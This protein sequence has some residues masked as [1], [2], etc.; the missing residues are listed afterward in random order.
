MK[1]HESKLSILK[2]PIYEKTTKGE[3]GPVGFE[4]KTDCVKTQS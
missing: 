3:G 4:P 1:A 2:D